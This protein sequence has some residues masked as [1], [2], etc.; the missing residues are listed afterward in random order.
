MTIID[1][2]FSLL[3]SVLWGEVFHGELSNE[4]FEEL[5]KLAQE[6]T[7]YGL[8]FDAISQ[9]NGKYEK[10][11]SLKAYAKTEKIKQKNALLDK[12]L[13]E[14]VLMFDEDNVDYLV[15]K[16]QTYGI[17]YRKPEL[18]MAGDIDFLI[19]QEYLSV[20]EVIERQFCVQLPEKV[21][22][23]EIEFKHGGVSFELHTRLR[24]YA[25]KRHQVV[26]DTLI[27]KEWRNY[28]NVEVDGVKVRTLSPT[29]N[30]AYVFIHLFFHFMR[31]GVALRQLC[32]WMM[33]LHYYREDID[34][35]ALLKI[36]SDL[37]L[38]DAY[39]AFGTILTDCLGL[40]VSEFPLP[41]DESDRKW[42]DR[43]I[44]DIFRGGNFGKKHHHT[45]NSWK[46]KMETM[47]LAMRNTIRYY[48]LCPSEV[49]GMMMRMVKGNMK[50]LLG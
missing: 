50:I 29:L 4:E 31:E 49:G 28:F 45:R 44:K 21:L 17:L 38:L 34:R 41:L 24:T 8:V 3:R 43:I 23:G 15:V 47:Q 25:K 11:Q 40:P 36:L 2:L 42:Q 39:R 14:L 30:A 9:L 22:D 37:D 13:K 12:E 48:W 33:V 7:V 26:W 32:D 20:R 5:M 16:G 6:Q 46:Y 1:K 10:R 27:E 35:N 18:R 19:Q